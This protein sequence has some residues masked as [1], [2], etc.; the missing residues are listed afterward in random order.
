M[1]FL[2]ILNHDIYCLI[3]TFFLH[4]FLFFICLINLF[5]LYIIRI[6]TDFSAFLDE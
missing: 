1:A 5:S 6:K 4:I 2:T 3:I